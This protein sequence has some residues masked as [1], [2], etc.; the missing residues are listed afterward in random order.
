M[1]QPFEDRLGN[2]RAQGLDRPTGRCVIEQRDAGAC[3]V[4]VGVVAAQD[5]AEMALAEDQGMVDGFHSD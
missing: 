5:L 3:V 4:V 1:V 2:E